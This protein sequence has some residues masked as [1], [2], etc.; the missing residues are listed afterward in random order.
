VCGSALQDG[1]DNILFGNFSSDEKW[2]RNLEEAI[3]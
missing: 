1:T 3:K 2:R